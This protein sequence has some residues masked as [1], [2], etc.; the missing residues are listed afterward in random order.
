MRPLSEFPSSTRK[1][2]QGVLF[3]IDDTLTTEGRLTATGYTTIERL[4]QTGFKTITITGRPAGVITSRACGQSMRW[5]A[6]T[7]RSIFATTTARAG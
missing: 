6:K 2:I 3:D 4:H 5:L 1:S 7:A